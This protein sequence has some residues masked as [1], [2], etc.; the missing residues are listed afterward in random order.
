VAAVGQTGLMNA[1]EKAFERYE[2]KVAQILLTH[3]D[4]SSRK[5]WI[6]FSLKPQGTI[7]IDAGAAAAILKNG[8]S[9]LPSGIFAVEEDFC[10]GNW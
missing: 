5:C 3:E 6:A 9:L 2:K 1:Y 7:T 4:L 8:K 10:P